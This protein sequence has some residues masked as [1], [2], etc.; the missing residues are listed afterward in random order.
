M[1][2]SSIALQH[3]STTP[4]PKNA[5]FRVKSATLSQVPKLELN[6]EHSLHTG[7][8]LPNYSF[9]DVTFELQHSATATYFPVFLKTAPDAGIKG[10]PPG[11]PT[12]AALTPAGPI[13]PTITESASIKNYSSQ[14]TRLLMTTSFL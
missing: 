1:S 3:P 7:S 4:R 10:K 13:S 5:E 6:W 9:P 14:C 8:F 2:A 12:G 11:F